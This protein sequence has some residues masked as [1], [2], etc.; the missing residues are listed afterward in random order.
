MRTIILAAGY[1]TRL[2]PVIGDFPKPL[3]EIG[4]ATIVDHVLSTLSGFQEPKDVVVVSNAH[5]FDHFVRWQQSAPRVTLLNDGST[6]VDSRR[7]AIGDIAYAIN[8]I[9]LNDDLLIVAADNVL[10]FSL[11]GLAAA[12][13]A[14]PGAYVGVRYNPSIEDQKRRG[15][16]EIDEAGLVTSFEEKPAEPKGHWAASP[17]YLLPRTRV[18]FV[19]DYLESG[20][21]PDAPGY[22]M[23]AFSK[24]FPLHAWRLPGD[25]LDIGNPESLAAARVSLGS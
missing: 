23:A 11:A 20:G 13:E 6:D 22:L 16:V 5:Y 19:H 4:G 3:V 10:R 15:V 12:F 8:E 7:G 21:N 9:K 25:I 1:G 24:Q 2:Q 18:P 17:I 14:R